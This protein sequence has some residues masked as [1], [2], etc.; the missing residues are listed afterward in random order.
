MN[1][2]V[3]FIKLINKNDNYLRV[4]FLS[5]SGNSKKLKVA[6]AICCIYTAQALPGFH[7]DMQL[8]LAGVPNVGSYGKTVYPSFDIQD[9]G[10]SVHG[11][12]PPKT[13]KIHESVT[14]KEPQP[15]P[16]KVPHPVPYPVHIPKPIPIPVTKIVHVPHSV[17][18][19]VI[20][21]IHV[22]VEVP[23]PYPVPAHEYNAGGHGQEQG[24]GHDLG[25]GF[26]G[27]HGFSGS[28]PLHSEALH[29]IDSYGQ[30]LGGFGGH[31]GQADQSAGYVSVA[32]ADPQDQGIQDVDTEKHE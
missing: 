7:G 24:H 21:P 18:V 10:T 5:F 32:Q 11:E 13:I 22:P 28:L 15:Y 31:E 12:I 23:K 27:G 20:K 14:I 26:G 25:G 2:L 30:G 1:A 6:F 3:S 16:V 9:L 29:N 4:F 19:E 17:P 8:I